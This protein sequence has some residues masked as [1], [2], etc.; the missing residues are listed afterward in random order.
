MSRRVRS[1][2][3]SCSSWL[4]CRRHGSLKMTPAMALGIVDTFW[5]VDQPL[6]MR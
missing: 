5:P 6:P 1:C 3:S 2:R 4:D